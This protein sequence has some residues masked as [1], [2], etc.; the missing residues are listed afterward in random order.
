MQEFKWNVDKH[1]ITLNLSKSE[2]VVTPSI[3]PHAGDK[4][5][6]CYHYGIDGCVVSYFVNTF[7]LETNTG[8]VP[9]EPMI[10]IAWCRDG[11]EWDIDLVQFLMIPVNDPYFKDWFESVSSS[12]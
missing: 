5:A 7:G 10:E 4:E 9:A 8:K 1:Y 2:L 12:S 11:S 3:C 6:A